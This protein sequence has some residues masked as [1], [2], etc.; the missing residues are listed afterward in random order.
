MRL[1]DDVVREVF[2]WEEFTLA[3]SL[4]DNRVP[5]GDFEDDVFAGIREPVNR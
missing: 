3:R 2:P 1:P 5:D 4:V